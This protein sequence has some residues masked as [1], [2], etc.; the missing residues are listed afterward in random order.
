MFDQRTAASVFGSIQDAREDFGVK[1]VY[2]FA[3][4]LIPG[5]DKSKVREQL[6]I[7]AGTMGMGVYDVRQVKF[8]ILSSFNRLLLLVSSVAFAAM[9][10]SALGVTNRSWRRSAAGDGSSACCEASAS[11]AADCSAWSWPKQRLVWSAAA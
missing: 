10:V 9:I 7:A 6:R 2:L 11:R 3:A 5:I 8:A 1:G 4:N